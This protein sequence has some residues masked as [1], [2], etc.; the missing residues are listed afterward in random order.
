MTTDKGQAA[1][2]NVF[3]D[4]KFVLFQTRVIFVNVSKLQNF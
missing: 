3:S 1:S 2:F 4:Q